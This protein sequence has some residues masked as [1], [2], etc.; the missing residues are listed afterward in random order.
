MIEV[1]RNLKKMNLNDYRSI[2]LLL[3]IDCFLF[4][5]LSGLATNIYFVYLEFDFTEYHHY[6][7]GTIIIILHI[8]ACYNFAINRFV[9]YTQSITH[10]SL[11]QNKLI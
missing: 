3:C 9:V 8:Y 7:L 6:S 10:N 4:G 1:I 5:F 2:L 11:K